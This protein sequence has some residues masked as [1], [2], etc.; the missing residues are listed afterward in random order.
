MPHLRQR[1]ILESLKRIVALSPLIGVLGHRQVGKTTLLENFSKHYLSMDDEDIMME[2]KTS[3][4]IFLEKY[5]QPLTVLD[6]CQLIPSLF[7]A[8]KE[9]V[10]KNKRPGQYI[11]TGSVRITSRKAIRESLTGRISNLELL[12][13][14]LGELHHLPLN[15]IFFRLD[16]FSNLE[17]WVSRIESQ[18]HEQH[19][20]LQKELSQYLQHGG[21]PGVCFIRDTVTRER[22][23][24]DQL[25]TILDRDI[26][27][28]YPTTVP[29]TQIFDFVCELAKN[30]GNPLKY[31]QLE[32][33]TKLSESTQKKLLHSL[34]S[35]FLL[36]LIPI[37]GDRRGFCYF[38]EDQAESR[39]LSQGKT[40]ELTQIEGFVYRHLRTQ[41]AYRLEQNPRYFHYKTRAGVRIPLC[42]SLPSCHL[43]FLFIQED[44][45]NRQ[46]MAAANSFFRSYNNSRAIFLSTTCKHIQILNDRS[47]ILPISSVF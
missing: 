36:R 32:K 9:T 13:F 10:R 17:N 41:W 44:Q 28:I 30:E 16:Q 31:S 4:K 24:L 19:K 14:T 5:K 8:L 45:P 40:S 43:A 39:F 15:D 22:K 27:L 47:A 42:L 26:R 29:Y 6:E 1:F 20:R 23:I 11:L 34:E 2:A 21:L 25:S 18:V 33:S 12:P 38:F 7:P 46:D 3:A 37:E 35:I